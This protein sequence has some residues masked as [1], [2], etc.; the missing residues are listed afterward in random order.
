MTPDTLPPDGRPQEEQRRVVRR[1]TLSRG[2]SCTDAWLQNASEGIL[3]HFLWKSLIVISTLLL[4]IGPPVR[5]W[6]PASASRSTMNTLFMLGFFIF[7]ID[8]IFRCYLDPNYFPCGA[9]HMINRGGTGNLR[10]LYLPNSWGSFDFWCDFLSTICFLF[11][12][13]WICPFR[14]GMEENDLE[15]TSLGFPVSRCDQIFC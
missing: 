3:D 12:V 11:E 9:C 15:L 1:S 7:V 10:R 5:V 14:F 13:T 2:C 4:L 6:F 8:M